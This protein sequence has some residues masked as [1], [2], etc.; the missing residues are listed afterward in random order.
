MIL[1][2]IPLFAVLA[3]AIIAVVVTICCCGVCCQRKP[4]YNGDVTEVVSDLAG[5]NSRAGY[6]PHHPY[7]EEYNADRVLHGL[8]HESEQHDLYYRL[9]SSTDD[10]RL[11]K[12]VLAG[13]EPSRVMQPYLGTLVG[14]SCRQNS[15]D[16][17]GLAGGR[18]PLSY[19]DAVYLP[20][21][22]SAVPPTTQPHTQN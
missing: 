10:Q 1:Y 4:K 19:G 15:R 6:E 18:E 8:Q 7:F 13:S 11:V 9:Y 17:R 22:D 16:M 5:A 21:A 14:E 3:L 12:A 2:F 20:C